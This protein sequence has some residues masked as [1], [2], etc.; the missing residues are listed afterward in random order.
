MFCCYCCFG[1]LMVMARNEMYW[2]ANCPE[3]GHIWKIY[4]GIAFLPSIV[5]CEKCKV[6]FPVN[7]PLPP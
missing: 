6:K 5:T 3:C 2:V 4:A 7:Y 1:D